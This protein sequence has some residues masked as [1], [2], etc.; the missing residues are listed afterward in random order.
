ME[1]AAESYADTASG[2]F[3]GELGGEVGEALRRQIDCII[4]VETELYRTDASQ[5]GTQNW[6][7]VNSVITL[8]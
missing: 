1:A 2:E 7:V 8:E 5:C 6:R 3:G 4:S